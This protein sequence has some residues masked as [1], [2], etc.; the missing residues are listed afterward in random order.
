MLFGNVLYGLVFAAL[1]GGLLA[2]I[3]LVALLAPYY[4]ARVYH[5][6]QG[7]GRA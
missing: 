5:H 3:A 4:S 7:A 6:R 2:T 1:Y